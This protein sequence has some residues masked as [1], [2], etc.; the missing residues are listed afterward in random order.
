MALDT[1]TKLLLHMDGVDQATTFI[2]SEPTPKTVTTIGSGKIVTAQSKFGGA[3]GS[4]TNLGSDGVTLADH[5]DWDFPG[6]FTIDFWAMRTATTY[7]GLIY[8]N[9]NINATTPGLIIGP[10]SVNFTYQHTIGNVGWVLYYAPAITFPASEWHHFAVVRTGTTVK[11]FMDGTQ[12]GTDQTDA[13]AITSTTVLS[14]PYRSK[15]WGFEGFIDEF[16]VSKGIARWTA[17]FTPP[18]SAYGSY[19]PQIQI[20]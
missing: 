14:I 2:D 18:T 11:L 19:T 4:F 17:N 3:S 5:A 7:F 12:V 9:S 8:A 13:V 20:F 6:D 15:P 16:R 1:Y 10:G